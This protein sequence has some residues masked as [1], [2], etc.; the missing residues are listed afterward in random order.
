MGAS[1]SSEK[2]LKRSIPKILIKVASSVGMMGLITMVGEHMLEVG[3]VVG[4]QEHREGPCEY[5][6]LITSATSSGVNWSSGN[7]ARRKLARSC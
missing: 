3:K 1:L 4:I 7:P 5:Y 2:A 6:V